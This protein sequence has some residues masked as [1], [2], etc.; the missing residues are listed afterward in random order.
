MPL[1]RQLSN[2]GL[3]LRYCSLQSP[4]QVVHGGDGPKPRIHSSITRT[5]RATQEHRRLAGDE[6][7][8]LV[9]DYEAGMSVDVLTGKW[10]LHRTT[11]MAHLKRQGYRLAVAWTRSPRTSWPKP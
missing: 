1:I 7:A 6:V 2:P 5:D 9:R 4:D 3:P 11:V 8:V 10:D